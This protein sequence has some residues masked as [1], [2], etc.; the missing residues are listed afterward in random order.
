MSE[1]PASLLALAVD[2]ARTAGQ[3]ALENQARRVEVD[4]KSVHDIK[5]RLDRETQD[6]AEA[7]LQKGCPGIPILGEEGDLGD[8]AADARWIVDPIDGTVNFFHGLPLWGCAV[9]FQELN[10]VTVAAIYLPALDECY[11]ATRDDVSRC[12]DAPISVST[13]PTLSE[14]MVVTGFSRHAADDRAFQVFRNLARAA[15]K[16]RVFGSAVVDLCSVACGRTDAYYEHGLN[17]G[18]WAAGSL[19]VRQAGGRF[20]EWEQLDAVK[21]RCLCS[22]GLVHDELKELVSRAGER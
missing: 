7:I 18:D 1:D 10:E 21:S 17:L 5:L 9:A 8:T 15:R 13:T 4:V 12:N 19:L 22:N 14:G 16:V 3:Y 2:A 11:T 6:Q 20:E